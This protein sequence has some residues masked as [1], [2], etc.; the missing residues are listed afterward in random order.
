MDLPLTTRNK[1]KNKNRSSTHKHLSGKSIDERPKV[2]QT[3]LELGHWEID[4]MI[5]KKFI[6]EATLVLKKSRY[7]IVR[8]LSFKSA[9][10]VNHEIN[11]IVTQY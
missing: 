10:F 2:I 3:R 1:T 6:N 5:G 9:D 8:K 11:K 4:L 7:A